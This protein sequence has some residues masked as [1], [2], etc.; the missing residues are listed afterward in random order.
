[1][2]CPGCGADATGAFCSNCGTR[3]DAT[4][5]CVRCG[6]AL[7]A[8]ARFCVQCGARASADARWL[9][10]AVP[11]GIA[12]LALLAGYWLGERGDGGA[13]A[14]S[15]ATV[16]QA[17]FAQQGG[18][19]SPPPLTG[20]MRDQA[21]RLFERIM[22]AR[23]RGDTA[24]ASFFLPMAL[25][26][27]EGA[28]S[29]DADGLFHLGLLQLEGGRAA[30]ALATARRIGEADANHLFGLALAGEAAMASGDRMAARAAFS[31]FL[32]QF[33]SEI[34]RELPEYEMHRPALDEYRQQ[35]LELTGS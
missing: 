6:S 28:G 31:Q 27:Y 4:R 26:A 17:P 14:S 25:Q 30:D 10:F 18:R 19:G 32:A 9:R 7:P 8:N 34:A 12:A 22:Q 13:T 33:D 5:P 21:D 2:K 1:M 20:S 29:L 35:A 3:L 24:E 11:A 23:A 16:A 15:A